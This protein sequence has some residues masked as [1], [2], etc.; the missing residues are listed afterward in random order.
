MAN[1]EAG[2]L[3]GWS[4]GT[5]LERR[6]IDELV[7]FPCIYAF[8]AVG[9][10]EGDFVSSLLS[11]VGAVLGREVR[12]D[13]TRVRESAQG[14]YQSVTLELFVTSGEQVYSIYEAMHADDRVRFLF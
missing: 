14:R 9:V 5:G 3:I 12:P 6:P 2:P 11:R 1:D 7:E 8:K 10:A 13:E 4:L